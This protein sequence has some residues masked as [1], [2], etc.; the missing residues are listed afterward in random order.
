MGA[1]RGRAAPR[2]TIVLVTHFMEEAER[3]CDRVALIESGRVVAL[4]TPAGLTVR[5]SSGKQVRFWPSAPFDDRLLLGRPEVASLERDGHH[6]TV[7]GSGELVNV[8][9]LALA[10]A[11]VTAHGVQ[12]DSSSLEDAFVRLTGRHVQ[13][14][15]AMS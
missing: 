8:V 12:L 3:L 6:V 4:D 15:G 13:P 11:G 1:D 7:T 9:I 2:V 10:A 5:A 14:E